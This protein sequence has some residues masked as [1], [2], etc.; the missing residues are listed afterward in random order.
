[1]W[2]IFNLDDDQ[3][4]APFNCKNAKLTASKEL[5]EQRYSRDYQM[6]KHRIR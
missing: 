6:S 3:I 1:M 5:R 4:L 2:S